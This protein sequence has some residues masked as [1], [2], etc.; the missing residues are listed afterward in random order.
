MSIVSK[1]MYNNFAFMDSESL[2]RTLT[3]LYQEKIDSLQPKQI[4]LV[5]QEFLAL[6][7]AWHEGMFSSIQTEEQLMTIAALNVAV[8]ASQDGIII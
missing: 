1:T 2:I 5:Q 4:L 6:E 3:A 7:Q 8:K